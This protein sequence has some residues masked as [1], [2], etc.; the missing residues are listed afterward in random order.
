MRISSSKST[1]DISDIPSK[2]RGRR[3]KARGGRGAEQM[4]E[5]AFEDTGQKK[6]SSHYY[7]SLLCPLNAFAR[8]FNSNT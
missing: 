4:S 2:N 1:A 5:I 7:A 6:S 3:R 8:H